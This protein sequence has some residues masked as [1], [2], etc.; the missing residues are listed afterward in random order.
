MRDY[1]RT[2]SKRRKLVAVFA[3]AGLVL[4]A[5]SFYTAT[6]TY[7]S[8]SEVL[9]ERPSGYV[10]TSSIGGLGTAT[11]TKQ[12]LEFIQSDPYQELGRALTEISPK[13]GLDLQDAALVD[14]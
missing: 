5:V 14:D 13:I 11:N 12:Q 6:P 7:R 2:I 10:I 1:V 8:T 3:L 9:I 4:G